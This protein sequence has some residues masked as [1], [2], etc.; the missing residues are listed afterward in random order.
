MNLWEKQ[1]ACDVNEDLADD[2]AEKAVWKMM[3][4]MQA[5]NDRREENLFSR[6]QVSLKSAAEDAVGR[7]SGELYHNLTNWEA[8][9]EDKMQTHLNEHRSDFEKKCEK[10]IEQLEPGS[11]DGV[12][13]LAEFRIRTEV[14]KTVD[15]NWKD[16]MENEDK[17]TNRN[18]ESLHSMVNRLEQEV[19]TLKG[20]HCISATSTVATS[21]GSGGSHVGA[22]I[23]VAPSVWLPSRIELKGWGV[24]SRI[25]ETGLPIDK[26][27]EL[28]GQ[29]KSL[30]PVTHH[31]KFDLEMT[32]K[33]QGNCDLKMMVFLWLKMRSLPGAKNGPVG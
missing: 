10:K 27:K 21:S 8:T 11:K 3:Q 12:I 15:K 26:V 9:L 31:D 33:E 28:V 29:V 19:T 23:P 13:S 24:W 5:E 18:I 17:I 6:F 7:L 14:Q 20:K 1:E 2:V 25:R 30:T 16:R 32:D 4:R 22:G